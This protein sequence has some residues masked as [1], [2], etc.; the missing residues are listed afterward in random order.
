MQ[1][2]E[3]VALDAR[4]RR[5]RAM[6]VAGS[7]ALA[8]AQ[9]QQRGLTVVALTPHRSS[10]GGRGAQRQAAMSAERLG[11]LLQELAMLVEAGVPLAEAVATLAASQ[12]PGHALGQLLARLRGGEAF[13]EALAGSGLRLPVFVLQLVRAGEA[14]GEL[15]RALRA[16]AEHLEAEAQFAREARNALLYPAVLVMSGVLATLVMFVFVVPKFAGILSNPKADLPLVSRWVLG[17]GLW[18]TQH[19][20][21]VGLALAGMVALGASLAGRPRVREAAWELATRTPVLARWTWHAEMARWSSLLAVLLNSRVPLL[22]ALAQANETLRR[23]S[24]RL[25]AQL[26]LADVRGGKSLSQALSDHAVLDAAGL[27]LRRVGERAG[28]LG[29]TTAALARTHTQHSQQRLKRL[30][31][32]LEPVTILLISVVLGGIMISVMLAITSLT[33]VL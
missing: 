22:T 5:Q 32:L 20:V 2:F 11:A 30:L 33:N 28:T 15:P 8:L 6:L 27:N 9:I 16:A 17:L 24:L 18:L 29:Q 7:E 12:P 19:Q 13:S 14:T 10:A 25:R 21:V 3:Y 26:V 1:E 31:V 23:R 4:G